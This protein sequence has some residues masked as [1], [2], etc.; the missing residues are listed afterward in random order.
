MN[1]EHRN[2]SWVSG[3]TGQILFERGETVDTAQVLLCL[4]E[5]ISWGLLLLHPAISV[6]LC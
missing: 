5:P 3:L 6:Q 1:H 2:L 4:E